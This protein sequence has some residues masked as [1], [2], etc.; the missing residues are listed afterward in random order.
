MSNEMFEKKLKSE[1]RDFYQDKMPLLSIDC[2][3]LFVDQFETNYKNL[4]DSI[5]RNMQTNEYFESPCEDCWCGC[6]AVDRLWY[7]PMNT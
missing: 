5:V 3:S 6:G 1:I 2:L 7:C 4:Y